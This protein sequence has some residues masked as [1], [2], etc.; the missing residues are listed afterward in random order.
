MGGTLLYLRP[1]K[2]TGMSSRDAHLRRNPPSS[3]P[4]TDYYMPTG[5]VLVAPADCTVVDLGG[6]VHPATG[7]YVTVDD[8]TRWIRYL[9]NADWG[10][11][12]RGQRLRRG[13][14]MVR[15]GASGYGSEFFGEP[16]RNAAFWR[17]TGGDHVHVTA[18]RGRAYTFGANG[19]V[20]FHALSVDAGGSIAGLPAE[21][22]EDMDIS[23]LYAWRRPMKGAPEPY[24]VL[25]GVAHAVKRAEEINA[26]DEQ[27]H[28]E[29]RGL[30]A[31]TLGSIRETY[32]RQEQINARDEQRHA[33]TRT[34]I[35]ALTEAVKVAS[36]GELS[37]EGMQKIVD[38][39]QTAARE[40]AEAAVAATHEAEMAELRGIAQEQIAA[41]DRD[42][43]ALKAQIEAI[44]NA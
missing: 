11:L 9:H 37:A 1:A 30:V 19:T 31:D 36:G 14:A 18:F 7:R 38:A 2:F 32:N 6:S 34:M 13:E 4:G 23:E 21:T 15:S 20:D 33:E 39:A 16:S 35:A 26:R 3:E 28:G 8:G 44:E 27:R 25:D 41:R 10:S 17:N 12:K 24:N 29:T 40:G 5:T 42:I 22:D 43:A